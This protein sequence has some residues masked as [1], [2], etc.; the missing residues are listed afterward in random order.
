MQLYG[1]GNISICFNVRENCGFRTT[2]DSFWQLFR[3]H[4]LPPLPT[5][6]LKLHLNI[7][8]NATIRFSAFEIYGLDTNIGHFRLFVHATNPAPMDDRVDHR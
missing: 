1:I 5:E 4:T 7:I 2:I 3:S 6:I 8:R